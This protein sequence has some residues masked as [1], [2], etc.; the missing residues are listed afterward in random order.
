MEI[1]DNYMSSFIKEWQE[2]TT[3]T[4]IKTAEVTRF[5]NEIRLPIV[6]MLSY[7]LKYFT[8]NTLAALCQQILGRF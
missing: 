3:H 6:G 7:T 4:K 8:N 1:I 5:F 2:L